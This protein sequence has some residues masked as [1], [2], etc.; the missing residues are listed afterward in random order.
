MKNSLQLLLAASGLLLISSRPAQAQ[1]TRAV[2]AQ[3]QTQCPW[4]AAAKNQCPAMAA[5]ARRPALLRVGAGVSLSSIGD[6]PVLRTHLE[7]A[8][9]LGARVR[10]ASRLGYLSGTAVKQYG[11]ASSGGS[12]AFEAPHSYR[13]VN[14]E[15]EVYWLPFGA[16]KRVEFGVGG[17]VF[18]SY[19]RAV[20]VAAIN[21]EIDAAFRVERF[22]YV[23]RR[24]Q[25]VHAGFLTSLYVDMALDPAATWR[26]GGRLSLQ[27]GVFQALNLNSSAPGGQ[28]QLSRA[29]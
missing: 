22:S 17:G 10:L 28:L 12:Y 13:A 2:P 23:P 1:C 15:Q 25:N 16:N 8:P 21:Y 18:L 4:L 27:S 26:L 14:A 19:Y 5:A 3:A 11:F 9:Q 6:F 20:S 24:E 7:Y 29:L